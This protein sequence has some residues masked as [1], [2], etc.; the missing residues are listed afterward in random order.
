MYRFAVVVIDM[1]C[2]FLRPW[3]KAYSKEYEKT[4]E[5]IKK[6]LR[7]AEKFHIPIIYLKHTYPLT[8]LATDWTLKKLKRCC[9]EK[10]KGSEIIE[11]IKPTKNAI[12]IEKKRYSGFLGTRLDIVLREMN[13]NTLII[14]GI[15]TNVCIRATVEDA[16][17]LGYRVIIP[18]EAVAT[19]DATAQK[20]HLEDISK[21]MGDVYP[22]ETVLREM[23]NA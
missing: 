4:I 10:D 22:L 1:I 23:K 11:E 14:V 12:I 18:Q 6:I 13:I 15:K 9:V 20:V 8:E 5:P 2:D 16:F 21:Y 7:E 19:N 3:G 17:S